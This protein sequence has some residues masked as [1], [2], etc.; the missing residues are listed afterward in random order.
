MARLKPCPFEGVGGVWGAGGMGR[1]LMPQV[2][3]HEWGTRRDVGR[4]V[5]VVRMWADAGRVLGGASGFGGRP[6][7]PQVRGHEWGTR[8]S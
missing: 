7:M 8:P 5:G 2:R 6:L 4:A 3:G 1:P